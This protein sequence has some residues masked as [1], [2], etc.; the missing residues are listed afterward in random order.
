MKIK[1]RMMESNGSG[2]ESCDGVLKL[3]IALLEERTSV[4][5]DNWVFCAL[6]RTSCS[7]SWSSVMES[8]GEGVGIFCTSPS[9]TGAARLGAALIY[10]PLWVARKLSSLFTLSESIH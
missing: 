10:C 3:P 5:R 2:G 4:Y 6:D 9:G 7:L 8:S 1:T